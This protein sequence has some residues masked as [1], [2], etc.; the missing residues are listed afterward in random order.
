MSLANEGNRSFRE[1]TGSQSVA[2]ECIVPRYLDA[3]GPYGPGSAEPLEDGSA[4]EGFDIKG[5][6]DSML[7]HV[8]GSRYYKAT[9]A[10]AWFATAEDAERAGFSAPPSAKD[11]EGDES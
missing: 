2:S 1:L 6:A 7:Y 8:P 10:E 5:N 11:E 4:P 3:T 9:K